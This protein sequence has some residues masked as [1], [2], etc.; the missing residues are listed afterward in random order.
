MEL[1]LRQICLVAPQLEPAV[2][3]LTS[4]LGIEVSWLPCQ[5]GKL[6]GKARHVLTR[7]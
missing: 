1:V 4:V 7:A 2:E 6:S 5:T 3:C